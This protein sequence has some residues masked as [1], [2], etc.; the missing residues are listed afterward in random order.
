[1][2]RIKASAATLPYAQRGAI[3]RALT[4]HEVTCVQRD[5]VIEVTCWLA[6]GPWRC[7]D[8]ELQP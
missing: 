7:F 4:H 8:I 3:L 1:V 6:D 2:A 5:D